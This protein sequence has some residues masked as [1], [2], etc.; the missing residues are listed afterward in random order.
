MSNPVYN[1]ATT[2]YFSGLYHRFKDTF[3]TIATAGVIAAAALTGCANPRGQDPLRFI[4]EVETLSAKNIN[5]FG[6][7]E[8]LLL[9]NDTGVYVQGQQSQQEQKFDNGDLEGAISRAGGGIYNY[10]ALGK[11]QLYLDVAAI[12]ET[13]KFKFKPDQGTNFEFGNSAINTVGKLG[14]VK[15]GTFDSQSVFDPS[16]TKI[17]LTFSQ[18]T[19]DMTGDIDGKY[20]SNRWTLEGRYRIGPD[21]FV[22]GGFAA[23]R[24]H[25]GDDWTSSERSAELG[26]VYDG[27]D[28][29]SK[30]AFIAIKG[31]HRSLESR[32]NNTESS[33]RH[34]GLS[35]TMGWKPSETIEFSIT[36]GNE[37]NDGDSD[38]LD[39]YVFG[40]IQLNL[41][42]HQKK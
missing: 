5:R 25:L 13:R 39:R 41:D 42:N 17:L 30:P 35:L 28:F 36:G 18:G 14:Y 38:G 7:N 23:K 10:S 31:T 16:L 29:L 6:T 22:D 33:S 11:G 12:P 4:A 21:F 32:M 34:P 26:I 1:K 9:G 20:T 40:S 37:Q 19:G 3:R 27:M 24:E 8:K 15:N 2:S